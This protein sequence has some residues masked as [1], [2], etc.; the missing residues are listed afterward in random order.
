MA[1]ILIIDD[2]WRRKRQAFAD[3]LDP[4]ARLPGGAELLFHVKLANS[5]G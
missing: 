2:I 3:L 5:V 4:F 1:N